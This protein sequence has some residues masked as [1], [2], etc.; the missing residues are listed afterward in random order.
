L[1]VGL[2]A[3]VLLLAAEVLLG[4]AISGRSGLEYISSRDP[5]SGSVYLASL[6]LY[7]ALPWLHARRSRGSISH[8][9]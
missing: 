7:A 5:V 9:A 4:V 8:E 3:L 6:V 1:A 2:F